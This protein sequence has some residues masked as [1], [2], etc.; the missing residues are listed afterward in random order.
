[1]SIKFTIFI[2]APNQ[3]QHKC[4]LIREKMKVVNLHNG[5]LYNSEKR[6]SATFRNRYKSHKYNKQKKP[7]TKNAWY[8]IQLYKVI[9]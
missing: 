8:M 5:I 7:V 3:K 4:P 1:M 2:M 9:K 6:Q